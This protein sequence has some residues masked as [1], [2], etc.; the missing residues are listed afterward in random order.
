MDQHGNSQ[1]VV[2]NQQGSKNTGMNVFFWVLTGLLLAP[3]AIGALI[4]LFGLLLSAIGMVV[5]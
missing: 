2:V 4:F 3:C 5:G 1:P